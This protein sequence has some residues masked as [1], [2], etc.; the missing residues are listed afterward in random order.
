MAVALTLDYHGA[1]AALHRLEGQGMK[2]GLERTEA[3]LTALGEPHR[4]LRGV[5]V[6]GTNGKGSVCALIDA[7][8]R[9][10]GR[11][12]GPVRP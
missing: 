6:A 11:S 5:L 8:A 1:L 7:M 3:L 2:L 4:G 10:A 9:A 12:L